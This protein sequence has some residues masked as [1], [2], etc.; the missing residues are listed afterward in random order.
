MSNSLLSGGK[1]YWKSSD[2]FLIGNNQEATHQEFS[3]DYDKPPVFESPV[4]RR[5]FMALLSASMAVGAAA[6]RRPDHKLVP[7]VKAVEYRTP[8]IPN[9]Y[10]TVYQNGNAAIGLLVKTTEGRPI[11]IDGNDRHSASMGVSS[12][13]IQASLLSL[14]DPDR[15]LRRP[16]IKG[17][18]SSVNNAIST[19]ADACKAAM[20]EGKSVRVLLHE[21][22]SPSLSALLSEIETAIPNLKFVT[23]PTTLADGTAAANSAILG[24]NGEMVPD[25]SKADVIVSVDADLLGTDKNSIYHIRNFS[26]KRKPTKKNP[27]MNMLIAVESMMSL[28]GANADYRF[29]VAPAEYEQVLASILKEVLASKGTSAVGAGV[30]SSVSSASNAHGKKIAE[31]LLKAGDKGVVVAG[32]HLSA[33]AN[34][35]ALCINLALGSVGA[36]KALN[37][38][39]VLPNSG[40]KS[41]AI[42]ALRDELKAKSVGVAVFADVNP[43]YSGDRDMKALIAGIGKRISLSQYADETSEICSITLPTTHYLE[44]WGDAVSFDGTL[45]IQQPMIAPLNES[46]IS[47]PDAMMQ[48][49]KALNP[50]LFAA[51]AT[52]FDYV[53]ARHQAALPNQAEW[54][55][56]LQNG[57]VKTPEIA[58][59]G[60]VTVNESAAA[61]WTVKSNSAMTGKTVCHIHLSPNVHDGDMANNGWMQELPNPVTK[62]TWGNV[63]AMSSKTAA[64][65]NAAIGDMIRIT[66]ANGSIEVPAFVQEG[67]A[68]DVVSVMTGYGRTAGGQVMKS[69]GGN[70][71]KLLGAGESLGYISVTM[72]KTGANE[73]LAITQGHNTIDGRDI[74]RDFTLADFAAGHTEH[75][76]PLIPHDLS[77]VDSYEYKGHRWGMT[78]DMSACIGC[79]ACTTACQVENNIPAVGKDQVIK[80]R[81]MHWIRLDRYYSTDKEGNVETLFQPM[82]C[83]HCENAPCENVCPVAATT[84][85]PEGLNEMTY[86]R[87]VGTRYCLNNCPYKVR[88]FNFLNWHKNEKTPMDL[89][90]NPDVTVRMRG[91]MEKCTF[92]VQRINEAKFHAKD[93]GR[94]RVNDGEVITA[95]Q[96]A[97]PAGAIIFGDMNDKTSRVYAS[98]NTDD[99]K[100]KVLEELNVRPSITYHGK[101]RNKVEHKA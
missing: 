17:G 91:I 34:A 14:Y 38:N 21:H 16:R 11:K 55:L 101:I 22:S 63:A 6:C 97:C 43:E 1:R 88:R 84:H 92:C 18:D 4:T 71:Y 78:I 89:V 62:V 46:S 33:N 57:I 19:I 52:Y 26:A 50:A 76:H 9:Y 87:C 13:R 60:A 40:V 7:S 20:A 27:E 90:F 32:A 74:V 68:D 69:V 36:D 37:T 12:S 81:E 95:C 54:E 51:T 72:E 98:K 5:T 8:G 29:P 59:A 86:N 39:H 15:V 75:E 30:A 61:Q 10:T 35:M 77:I 99:R 96:Q 49:A 66:T 64:G 73:T 82:L 23:L 28:T 42:N 41:T 93:H 2:E 45:S 94:A 79:N 65:M 3:A 48:I 100:F 80:G 44:E 67:M 83:Q 24:V 56:A 85:S 58:A 31:M 25:L 47:I 70:A 53:R